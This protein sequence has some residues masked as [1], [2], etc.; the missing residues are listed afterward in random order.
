LE[1]VKVLLNQIADPF[2]LLQLRWILQQ[3][4]ESLEL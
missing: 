3:R 2:D 1:F 4:G